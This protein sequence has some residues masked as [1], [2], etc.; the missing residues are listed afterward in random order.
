MTDPRLLEELV[1]RGIQL[2][3]ALASN[4]ALGLASGYDT[5]A[6]HA[7]VA[8]G[9]DVALGTDDFTLFGAGLCDEIRS[10]RR[11]GMALSE[12]AKLRLGPPVAEGASAGGK[13]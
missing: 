9:V 13:P 2:N 1:E 10:L 5:H 11:A 12:L 6:I 7:L 8:A 3:L 4:L